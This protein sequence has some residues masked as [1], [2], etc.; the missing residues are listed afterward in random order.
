ML[1]K[2]KSHQKNGEEDQKKSA[3]DLPG[4]NAQIL[5]YFLI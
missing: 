4:L 2:Q 1:L 5:T 3:L